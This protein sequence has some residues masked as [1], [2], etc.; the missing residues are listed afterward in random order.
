MSTPQNGDLHGNAPE[1]SPTVILIID[2]INDFEFP[3]GDEL[4]KHTE[5]VVNC[6]AELRKKADSKKIPVIYVNDNFGKWQSDFRTLLKHCLTKTS[7]SRSL[8][9]IIKPRRKDYFVLKPKNSGF[10]STTLDL[11]LDYLKAETLIITGLTADV[12]ILMTAADAF[13]RDYKLLVPSDCTAS[14]N[15]N[16]HQQA[17]SYIKRVLRA[18]TRPSDQIIF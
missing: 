4:I 8:V 13:L 18:D 1:N 11:L 16:D 7:K 3:G 2:I 17:L 6:I 14:I 5:P 9:G 12:C 15:A 10:Y